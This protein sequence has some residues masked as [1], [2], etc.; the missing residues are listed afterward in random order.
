[1]GDEDEEDLLGGVGRGGDGVGGE[2]GQGDRLGQP[3][4]LLARARARS[5]G[6]TSEALQDA[7]CT[8]RSACHLAERAARE[9]WPP[10]ATRGGS[11]SLGVR[12][13]SA[14]TSSSS[15][16]VGS[17]SEL[18]GTL[19]TTVTRVAVDRQDG[20]GVPAPAPGLRR[21]DGRSASASTATTCWSAGIEQAGGAGRRDQRRQLQHPHG[22][23]RPGDL[24]HRARRGP[25]LRPP[26]GR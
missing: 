8:W 15:D 26:P 12:G 4:V 21:V 19:E 22:P 5:G 1:M 10:S 13:G 18:A 16:A 14:C 24:R 7:E 25:H 3:L 2:D 17:G 6:P 11:R 9:V 23:R 20:R